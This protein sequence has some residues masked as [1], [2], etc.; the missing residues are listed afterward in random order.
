MKFLSSTLLLFLVT[1]ATTTTTMV[2]AAFEEVTTDFGDVTPTG[3]VFPSICIGRNDVPKVMYTLEQ[4]NDDTVR[5]LTDPPNLMEVGINTSDGLLYFKFEEEALDL[6]PFNAGVRVQF[7]AKQLDSINICCGQDLQVKNGFT[8][9]STLIVSTGATAQAIFSTNNVNLEVTVREQA[10]A[11]IEVN[12]LRDSEIVVTGSGA[13]T[14]VDISGDIESIVCTERATCSVAGAI[15]NT[16]TSSV[17]RFSILDTE[18][19]TGIKVDGGSTCDESFPFVS[20]NVDGKLTISGVTEQCIQGGELDGNVSGGGGS[21]VSPAPTPEG[22]TRAPTASPSPTVE[23]PTPSPINRPTPS[24]T[25][26]TT[27]STSG[28]ATT[29]SAAAAVTAVIA[30]IVVAV[31]L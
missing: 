16:A 19:C 2:S 1:A 24:P 12:A 27:I 31:L 13:G 28:V 7:P 9:V 20:A 17:E 4:S 23:R 11:T 30:M 26:G 25:P 15:A 5:V 18:D 29:N 3:V 8:D 6:S 10:S 22:F 21:T 14:F